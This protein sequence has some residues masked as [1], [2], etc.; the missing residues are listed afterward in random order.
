MRDF[1]IEPHVGLGPI[2]LGANRAAVQKMLA[3]MEPNPIVI[4]ES[5]GHRDFY[6]GGLEISADDDGKIEFIGVVAGH[7]L[8]ARVLFRGIDVFDTP[9][10]E[11]FKA[12]ANADDSGKHKFVADEH[13]F[14]NQVLTVQQA[15][16]AQDQRTGQKPRVIWKRVGLGTLSYYEALTGKRHSRVAGAAAADARDAERFVHPKLGAAVLISR[17][18]EGEMETLELRFEDG[19]V[20]KV[21][22][23]FV[24]PA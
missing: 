12:F 4:K 6:V 15:E 11:V 5:K 23:S 9:A 24:T 22:A 20:R 14:P 21:R 3:A 10:R 17:A 13:V 2:L 16:T 1:V 19:A 7:E 8:G 18:G